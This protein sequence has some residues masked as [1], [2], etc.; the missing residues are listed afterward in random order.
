[1]S[2]YLNMVSLCILALYSQQSYFPSVSN[3]PSMTGFHSIGCQG[4]LWMIAFSLLD[5]S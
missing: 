4:I 5:Y 1:M 2:P 3:V